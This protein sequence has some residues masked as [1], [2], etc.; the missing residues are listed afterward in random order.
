[1]TPFTHGSLAGAQRLQR[2]AAADKRC[3]D[4]LAEL[5]FRC[6]CEKWGDV[7]AKTIAA[8]LGRAFI[9]LKRVVEGRHSQNGV[10]TL[11]I[12]QTIN[13]TVARDFGGDADLIDVEH[14]VAYMAA[15]LGSQE[16][17]D[18][19]LS[20]NIVGPRWEAL[21]DWNHAISRAN[22]EALRQSL[23]LK[24]HDPLAHERWGNGDGWS[25]PRIVR[26]HL[27]A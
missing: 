4:V 2:F 1:M 10:W 8:H 13:H 5:L 26:E 23:F 17:I 15:T 19:V 16:G 14:N 11:M 9:P 6:L 25:W 24:E 27:R 7:H 3:S 12:E 21:I 20:I 22:R 18:R